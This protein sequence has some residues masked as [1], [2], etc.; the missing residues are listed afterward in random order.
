[1][2]RLLMT[3]ELNNKG[4]K[5]RVPSLIDVISYNFPGRI[6]GIHDKPRSGQPVIRQR[7]ELDIFGTQAYKLAV[8]PIRLACPY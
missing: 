4:F 7:I 2:I 5:G 3:D 8:T 1:M 6:K